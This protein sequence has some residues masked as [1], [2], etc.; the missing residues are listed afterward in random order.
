MLFKK[1]WSDGL[2]DILQDVDEFEA[3]FYCFGGDGG[4][5]SGGTD[6]KTQDALATAQ[7]PPRGKKGIST[8][9]DLAETVNAM[10]QKSLAEKAANQQAQQ[11]AQSFQDFI[12][13]GY[14]TS[15]PP[16]SSLS[17]AP[18]GISIADIPG[19]QAPD[20]MSNTSVAPSRPSAV[21]QASFGIG[22]LPE[23]PATP[24]ISMNPPT[25]S[26]NDVAAAYGVSPELNI[27]G[28][29]VGFGSTPGTEG[30]IAGPTVG[31]GPGTLGIGTNLGQDQFGIGYSMKFAKGGIVT[32]K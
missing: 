11:A 5:S 15:E 8:M 22:S 13:S 10:A 20:I 19:I 6:K 26:I 27:G 7:E 29:T 28:Y 18:P 12:S 1:R 21:T 32:L 9:D 23:A 4:S 2:N 14:K 30:G 31:V 25:M 17:T 24:Q 3:K 16:A